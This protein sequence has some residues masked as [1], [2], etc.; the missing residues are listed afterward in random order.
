M[1]TRFPCGAQFIA[2]ERRD[3]PALVGERELVGTIPKSV[4]SV[5]LQAAVR[6][7]DNL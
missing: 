3:K 6:R 1:H 2:S 7:S 5:I 4:K